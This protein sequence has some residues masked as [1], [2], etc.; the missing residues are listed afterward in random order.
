MRGAWMNASVR[1]ACL[2]GVALAVAAGCGPGGAPREALRPGV[3]GP[4]R[5]VAVSEGAIDALALQVAGDH[6]VVAWV[7]AGRPDAVRLAWSRDRGRSFGAPETRPRPAPSRDLDLEWVM[8]ESRSW[9][10]RFVEARPAVDLVTDPDARARWRV[11]PMGD[12]VGVEVTPPAKLSDV[13]SKVRIPRPGMTLRWAGPDEQL[14]LTTLWADPARR[15]VT[16]FRYPRRGATHLAARSFDVPLVLVSGV[17][18][19]ARLAAAPMRGGVFVAWVE[20]TGRGARIVAREVGLDQ[21]CAP[22]PGGLRVEYVS[23]PATPA[24]PAAAAP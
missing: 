3:A 10:R 11:R 4:V 23:T 5:T 1:F 21:L 17:S 7:D 16:L 20:G 18:P 6:V 14:N 19:D 13:S 15:T 9:W 22:L 2:C 8:V 24:V 12:G